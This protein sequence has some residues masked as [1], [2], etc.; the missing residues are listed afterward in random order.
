MSVVFSSINNALIVKKKS[1][2]IKFSKK[3]FLFVTFL[4]NQ[5]LISN[6]NLVN[7]FIII[8]FYYKKGKSLFQKI[9]GITPKGQNI[10]LNN[11][12]ILQYK[13]NNFYIFLFQT[14]YGLLEVRDIKKFKTG[15]T[16]VC[17]IKF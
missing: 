12:E 11:K 8:H 10:I 13:K 4:F 16:L 1:V 3:N 14:P 2:K 5:N 6:Y 17:K 15:G 9:S 7:D